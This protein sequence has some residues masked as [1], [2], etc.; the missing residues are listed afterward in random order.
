MNNKDYWEISDDGKLLT[1]EIITKMRKKFNIYVYDEENIDKDFP[2]PKEPTTRYFKKNIEADEEYK[3]LSANDLEEK[4]I[5]GITLRERL[6]MELDYFNETNSHLDVDNITLCSGSRLSYG[7][8]PFVHW[9]ADRRRL[10]VYWSLPGL[11]YSLLRSRA[12]VSLPLDPQPLKTFDPTKLEIKY[13][14]NE[15]CGY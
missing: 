11:R 14:N 4:K 5:P 15:R 8:V 1:S 7:F 2:T 6:L 13:N 9:H 3:N 12:A 10:F